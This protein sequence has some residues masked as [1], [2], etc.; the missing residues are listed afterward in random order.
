MIGTKA[1][2][3]VSATA[4][5]WMNLDN[6]HFHRLFVQYHWMLVV[7]TPSTYEPTFARDLTGSAA[8]QAI[9]PEGAG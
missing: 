3:A 4:L 9:D 6:W 2:A 8:S 7:A 5:N 1:P